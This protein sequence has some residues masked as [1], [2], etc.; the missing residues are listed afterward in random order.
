MFFFKI[1]CVTDRYKSYYKISFKV[2]KLQFSVFSPLDK[3][4]IFM[5]LPFLLLLRFPLPC[6][7]PFRFVSYHKFFLISRFA[8]PVAICWQVLQKYLP[9][10]FIVLCQ[11]ETDDRFFELHLFFLFLV[12]AF[13]VGKANP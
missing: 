12:Y 10:N 7:W 13:I 11:S 9:L 8:S 6:R 2:H 4:E 1:L 5:A 3:V